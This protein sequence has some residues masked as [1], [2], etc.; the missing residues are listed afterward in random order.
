MIYGKEKM[1]ARSTQCWRARKIF[2]ESY[3]ESNFCNWC[4]ALINNRLVHH[5]DANPDNNSPHNLW[6]LC[7][8]ECHWEVHEQVLNHP[9]RTL[10]GLTGAGGKETHRKYRNTDGY[11]EEQSRRAKFGVGECKA[12]G[13]RITNAKKIQC[14]NCDRTMN[15]GALGM[16]KRIH[17]GKEE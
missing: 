6:A 10:G 16:H 1:V 9:I 12:K 4:G 11:A 14:P 2:T 17:I 5:G 13:A 7:S 15:P 8:R 3:R